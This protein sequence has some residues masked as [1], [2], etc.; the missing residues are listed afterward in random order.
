MPTVEL[1]KLGT[2]EKQWSVDAR[3]K[4]VDRS[5]KVSRVDSET[6]EVRRRGKNDTGRVYTEKVGFCLK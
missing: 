1:R 4:T 3:D 5:E 2:K 6:I